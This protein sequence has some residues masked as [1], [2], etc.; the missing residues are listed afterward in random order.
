M[1]GINETYI[2]K[3]RDSAALLGLSAPK[4]QALAERLQRPNTFSSSTADQAG[5]PAPSL[6]GQGRAVH[7]K[8]KNES[9]TAP[10]VQKHVTSNKRKEL[11]LLNSMQG[12]T[13]FK[14]IF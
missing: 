12:V 4:S 5:R 7:H 6:Q 9:Q 14:M 13:V 1:A 8:Y 3:K 10:S 11:L 2:R